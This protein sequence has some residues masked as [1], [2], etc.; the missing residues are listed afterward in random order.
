VSAQGGTAGSVVVGLWRD[1]SVAVK[2]LSAVTVACLGMLVITFAALVQLGE[3]RDSAEAMNTRAVEPMKVMDEVRRAYLQTRTDALADEWVGRSD[4][5]SDHQAFLADLVAMDQALATLREQDLSSDQQDLVAGA[6]EAWSTYRQDV[7]GPLLKLARAGDRTGYIALRNRDVRPA[8]KAIQSD[9]TGLATSLAEQ[10]G[11]QV[12]QN[13]ASY[14]TARTVLL[15]VGSTCLL[16]A[17]GLAVLVVRAIVVPLRN[18]RDVCAA[19]ADGDLTRRV[20]LPGRDEIAQ[21]AQALDVAAAATQQAMRAVSGSAATLAGAA[22]EL[23][24]TT[25][26]IATSTMDA[27]HQATSATDAAAEVSSNVQSVAAGAE[28]LAVAIGEIARTAAEAA[29]LGSQAGVLAETTTTTVSKLGESSMEIGNVIRLITSIAE[30]TNLLALN[31]TIE[32]ARAG[33]AGKGFAVVAHEVKELAQETARAT[34][35]I[36]ARVRA[37]QEDTNG[38]VHAIS[39]ISTVIGQLG[40]FQTTIAAAVEQQSA[41]TTEITR[42]VTTASERTS[43][44]ASAVSAVSG[45][46]QNIADGTD[47]AR[48]ASGELSLMSTELHDLIARFRH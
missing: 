19:V 44:I 1:R 5:G 48:T 7:A 15:A 12:R 23:S 37:I 6:S 18:V 30:Q 13:S 43:R 47:Q 33:E 34:E 42:S 28:Q 26:V 21:T 46:T 36:S 9:L 2:L 35:D 25:G 17:I 20:D 11:A 32:A 39:E 41:T 38:A 22:E 16:L 45:A 40:A 14:R 31:A 29:Q 8:A 27:S 10:T 4:Q 3:L 24:A